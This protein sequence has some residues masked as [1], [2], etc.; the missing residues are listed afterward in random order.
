MENLKICFVSAVQTSFWGSS[1]E[2]YK[3]HYL[4]EMERLSKQLGFE[5]QCI[6]E[7]IK[8]GQDAKAA[9]EKIIKMAPDFLMIQLSTFSAGEILLPLAETNVRIGLWGIPEVTESGAIPNNSFCGMNMYAGILRQYFD[10]NIKYKWFY[11]DTKD[12]LFL[13]RF[14][15]TVKALKAIKN[16]RGSKLALVG[17]VVPG[18]YDCLFDERATANKL[19]VEIDRSLEFG[20]IKARALAYTSAEIAPEIEAMKTEYTHIHS[21]LD[22]LLIEN[23]VR[24][25]KAFTDYCEE[26]KYD[27]VAISCWPRYR[28]ELG[29]VVCAVIGRLLEHGILAACEG[30]VDS[31]IS[32][33]IL[34]N[35]TQEMPMLMDLSKF[36]ESDNSVMMW[37]CGSAPKRYADAAGL[38]LAGHYKPGSRV[39]GADDIMVA[40]VNDLYYKNSD[41]TVTRLTNNYKNMLS[42]T[43][44]FI[45]KNNR[46]YDGSRGWIGNLS[47][48]GEPLQARKLVNTVLSQGFQHHY[49]VVAG[50]VEEELFE[51]MAWLGIKPLQYL[52]YRNYLQDDTLA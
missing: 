12:E 16:L 44:E 10:P 25:Y 24:V 32:M 9:K 5:L 52:N 38:T 43:G 3:N 41:V 48:D 42:F 33:M 26:N 1:K 23:T 31:A 51:V 36:D 46:G 4:P 49:A 2:E 34:R 39:T 40:G 50:N 37:H 19:G 17:G 27:A 8:D 18:F 22:A 15:I 13:K 6:A 14:Q 35:L 11:G 47:H 45:A 21:N 20:D 28:K 30:D 29:I 7:P